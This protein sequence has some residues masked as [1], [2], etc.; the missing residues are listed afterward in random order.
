MKKI[1]L[2][3]SLVVLSFVVVGCPTPRGEDPVISV[4]NPDENGVFYIYDTYQDEATLKA[5]LLDE[6]GL[7]VVTVGV[8]NNDEESVFF[9]R[10]FI[11]DDNPD[12][13]RVKDFSITRYFQT[14]IPRRYEIKFVLTDVSGNQVTERVFIEYVL[15]SGGGGD[16]DGPT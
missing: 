3:F 7:D 2:V 1:S 14:D 11:D 10:I 6:N 9:D 4:L 15:A 8:Y 13:P 16:T 5:E 12:T